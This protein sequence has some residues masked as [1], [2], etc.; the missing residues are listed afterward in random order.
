MAIDVAL[1]SHVPY[2][3]RMLAKFSMRFQIKFGMTGR[4]DGVM[5]ERGRLSPVFC[6]STT[7]EKRRDF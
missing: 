6:Y 3:Q 1:L 5:C 7:G 4:W 2:I